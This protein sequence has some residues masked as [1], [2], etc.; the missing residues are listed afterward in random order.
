[1]VEPTPELEGQMSIN[2]FLP[3]TPALRPVEIREP[4]DVEIAAFLEAKSN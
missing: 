4:T 3:E 1:M 2:S